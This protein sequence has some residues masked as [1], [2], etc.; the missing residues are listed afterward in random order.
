VKATQCPLWVKSR[1]VRRKKSCPLNPRKRTCA[2]RLA[3]SAMG[4][5]RT[6]LIARLVEGAAAMR[7]LYRTIPSAATSNKGPGTPLSNVTTSDGGKRWTVNH[8]KH[9]VLP[10]NRLADVQPL[11]CLVG[12]Y[13]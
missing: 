6:S 5:K 9:A 1:H 13:Q 3:M 10:T 11:E 2:V 4:Q 12:V 7:C 8:F